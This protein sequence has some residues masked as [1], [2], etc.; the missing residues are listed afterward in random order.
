[1]F[2]LVVRF[3]MRPRDGTAF[4]AFIGAT[5][6]HIR[7]HEPGTLL[8]LYH[9]STARLPLPCVDSASSASY[10]ATARRS[11]S[12]KGA[13]YDAVAGAN[14]LAMTNTSASEPALTLAV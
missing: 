11:M 12:T 5:L 9:A 1:M 2:S 7:A 8:Y 6:P 3:A 4:D 10:I 13:I 14:E